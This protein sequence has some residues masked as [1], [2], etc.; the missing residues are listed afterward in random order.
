MCEPRLPQTRARVGARGTALLVL[1]AF[2]MAGA[3]RVMAA[4]A[5]WVSLVVPLVLAV[6]VVGV[7]VVPMVVRHR[8]LVAVDRS[9]RAV[10]A[11]ELVRVQVV[12]KQQPRV[13]AGPTS[14]RVTLLEDPD[15]WRGAVWPSQRPALVQPAVERPR[16]RPEL[17]A[18]QRR[19][20]EAPGEAVEV[21][22]WLR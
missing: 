3:L 8:R 6:L 5:G 14:V 18:E 22:G 12:G 20:L 11:A 2:G 16:V 1:A 13:T 10:A 21:E 7:V 19:A 4:V 17:V 9:R 15:Y